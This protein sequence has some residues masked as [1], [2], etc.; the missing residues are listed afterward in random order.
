M[1]VSLFTGASVNYLEI[2]KGNCVNLCQ[3]GKSLSIPCS[4]LPVPC[5]LS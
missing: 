1:S 5:S 4:L 3:S 2:N